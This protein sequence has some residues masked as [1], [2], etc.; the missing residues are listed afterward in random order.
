MIWKQ[1]DPFTFL[2]TGS[3]ISFEDNFVTEQ[4]HTCIKL[5]VAIEDIKDIIAETASKSLTAIE[6]EQHAE[7]SYSS[8]MF[9]RHLED[10]LVKNWRSL[11]IGNQYDIY[12]KDGA[13]VGQQ[14]R[15]STGPID[16]LALNKNKKDFLVVELKRDRASDPVI[17]QTTRYMGWVEENLCTPQQS[18]NGLIIA[19]QQD[20]NLRLSLSQNDK[21]RFL[22]Y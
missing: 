13:Q 19:H 8:F 6:I 1:D 16:I 21:I 9:E 7:N 12:E 2:G 10:F 3:I 17:G 14:F 11:P 18:V 15:T 22:R 20:E 5:I 4:G